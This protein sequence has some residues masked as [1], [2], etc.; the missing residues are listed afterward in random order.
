VSVLVDSS[1]WIDY[2]RG[3][4]PSEQLDQL[5]DNNLIVINELILAELIPNL[6]AL[7][8]YT[9]ISLL[10]TIEKVPLRIDWDEIIENQFLCI[11]NGVNRVGIPDLIIAQCAS[12]NQLHLYSND[13]HFS[14]MSDF[15]KL[16]LL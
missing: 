4:D 15:L 5:I 13:K 9:L 10:Q 8:Q 16:D 12:H 6:K 3:N 1:I 2:F 11:R 14:L 7:K